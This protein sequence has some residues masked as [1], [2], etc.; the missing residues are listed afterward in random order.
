MRLQ[1]RPYS[2]LRLAISPRAL[3]LILL[4]MIQRRLQV[5]AA[6][7]PARLLWRL[8]WLAW[9]PASIDITIGETPTT[10]VQF[11]TTTRIL[12]SRKRPPVST[13]SN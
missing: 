7:A 10:K 6:H 9:F 8:F 13:Q 3:F 1:T 12:R 2:F 11:P 5:Q 4:G